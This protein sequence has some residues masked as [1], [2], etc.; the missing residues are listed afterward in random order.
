M[1]TASTI[2]DARARAQM[3]FPYFSSG[4]MSLR[5]V[6]KP[7]IRTLAIDAGWR[8]YWDPAIEWT[9]AQLAAVMGHELDHLLRDHH[10]RAE[11]ISADP[12][13]YNIAGDAEINDD[14]LAAGADLPAGVITPQMLGCAPGLLAEHYYQ[15]IQEKCQAI[16]SHPNCGSCARPGREAYE[17]PDDSTNA[18]ALSPVEASAVRQQV[19]AEIDKTPGNVP[20]GLRRWA[21]ATLAPQKIDWR[22]I[23]PVTV[24]GALA[25]GGAPTMRSYP[26]RRQPRYGIL[27][28]RWKSIRPSIAMVIDT[29][30]SISDDELASAIAITRSAARMADLT[31]FA[32]DTVATRVR[33]ITPD[34]LIGGGGTDMREGIRV[35]LASRPSPGAIVVITDCESPWEESSP[36]VPVIIV[37]ANPK[38]APA[39]ARVVE[40]AP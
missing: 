4:L 35:A 39:W 27:Q 3:L 38:H 1:I 10:A 2:S 29:S 5:P 11:A 7:G 15:Q 31:I 33:R 22:R 17:D 32:C 6:V 20:A 36:G 21:E 13:I 9:L 37:T 25:S 14:H 26:G 18:P 12:L 16:S 8:M 23:L 19:A 24:R 30:G 40:L 34:S 28:P